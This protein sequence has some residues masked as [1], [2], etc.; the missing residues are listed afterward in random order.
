MKNRAPI[1]LQK[2]TNTT[3]YISMTSSSI[4][5]SWL[6][7]GNKLYDSLVEK[8]LIL[9]LSLLN[10]PFRCASDKQYFPQLQKHFY[11]Q[12][13]YVRNAVLVIHTHDS[14]NDMEKAVCF[15]LQKSIPFTGIEITQPTLEDV[16]LRLTSKSEGV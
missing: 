11:E 13:I 9:I 15:L 1:G 4:T 10:S 6:I 5:S 7:P 12:E 2:Q 3:V 8:A 16:F 14:K